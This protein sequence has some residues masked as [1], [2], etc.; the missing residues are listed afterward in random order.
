MRK[1][2]GWERVSGSHGVGDGDG[3]GDG[4]DERKTEVDGVSRD[5]KDGS[6]GWKEGVWSGNQF[7]A[8]AWVGF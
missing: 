3:N 4:E 5:G 2:G 8:E 6:R 1:S 7:I